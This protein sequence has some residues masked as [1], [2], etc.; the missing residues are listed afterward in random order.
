MMRNDYRYFLSI[1][2]RWKDNDLFSHLNNVEYYSYVDT[3]TFLIRVCGLDIH[4]GALVPLYAESSGEH[5]CR[6]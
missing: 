5:Q 1:P 4:R 2:T 6:R 3:V